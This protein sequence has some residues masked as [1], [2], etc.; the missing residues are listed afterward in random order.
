[1]PGTAPR[2]RGTSR[3]M[4]DRQV[5]S[6][7]ASSWCA[8][9]GICR[10]GRAPHLRTAPAPSRIR[11]RGRRP[12]RYRDQRDPPRP[13]MRR[14]RDHPRATPDRSRERRAVAHRERRVRCAR[15]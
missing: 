8:R 7:P 1:V 3:G 2:P 6:S 11:R 13:R 10:A 5:N 14:L 4:N 9:S 15:S 12:D